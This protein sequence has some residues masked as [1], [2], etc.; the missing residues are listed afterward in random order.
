MDPK[1]I[2]MNSLL[3]EFHRSKMNPELS[4][5]RILFPP[6]EFEFSVAEFS[7]KE[8]NHGIILQVNFEAAQI[9]NESEGLRVNSIGMGS[10]IKEA[11]KKAAYQWF[12]GV[13]PVLHSYAS[14]HDTDRGVKKADFLVQDIETQKRFA[15]KAHLGQ[16][17]SIAYGKGENPPPNKIDRLDIFQ[18]IFNEISSITA[19]DTMMWLELFAS[20]YPDGKVDSTCLLRNRPW[21][22]GRQALLNYALSWANPLKLL[23][24]RRQFVILEPVSR[25][26]IP[27]DMEKRLDEYSKNRKKSFFSK[28]FKRAG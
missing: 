14:Q 7:I 16:I 20:Q 12:V 21:T 24:S 13:F 2:V 4:N 3:D 25:E 5:N 18:S 26:S 22:D 15:W 17:I 8:T 19:T 28:F 11:S 6:L 9:G 23:L 10:D 27:N 1:T